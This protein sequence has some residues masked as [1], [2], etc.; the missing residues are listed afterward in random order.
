MI[1]WVTYLYVSSCL[2]SMQ[3]CYVKKK[4]TWF[5]RIFC[6]SIKSS[7]SFGLS[8]SL[9]FRE[10]TIVLSLFLH[11]FSFSWRLFLPHVGVAP[12]SMR[13]YNLKKEAPSGNRNWFREISRSWHKGEERAE[14]K[15]PQAGT[16][17]S[18]FSQK[19]IRAEMRVRCG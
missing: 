16:A 2:F 6:L 7:V 1:S 12:N 5:A 15:A 18:E 9:R 19:R 14:L 13:R 11:T 4:L 10:L 17:D 3:E 8:P